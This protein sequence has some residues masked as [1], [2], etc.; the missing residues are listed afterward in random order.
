M[1]LSCGRDYN[2]LGES[3]KLAVIIFLY[4]RREKEDIT[5][6]R[7]IFILDLHDFTILRKCLGR[8]FDGLHGIYCTSRSNL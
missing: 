2:N 7:P 3:Y 6:W 8:R 4:K 5:N 1:I